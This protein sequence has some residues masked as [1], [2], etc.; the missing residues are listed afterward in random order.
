MQQE[1]HALFPISLT[2]VDPDVE[3]RKFFGAK[4]VA[5]ANS[6]SGSPA[7]RRPQAEHSVLTKPRA[8]WWSGKMR[9]GLSLRALDDVDVAGLAG[10]EDPGE[11][12]STVK[13]SDRYGG[14]TLA[15]METVLSGGE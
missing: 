3:P 6:A 8:G 7:R 13:Y 14:I 4:V 15:F 12:W 10:M 9:D 1:W 5:A 11:K 2:H